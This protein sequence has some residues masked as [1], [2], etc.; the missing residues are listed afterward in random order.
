MVPLTRARQLPR[1]GLALVFLLAA[2]SV[3]G[4][5]RIQGG[6]IEG[7]VTADPLEHESL[8]FCTL[9]VETISGGPVGEVAMIIEQDGTFS[10]DLPPGT[11]DLHANC[12]SLSGITSVSVPGDV[13]EEIEITVR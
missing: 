7:R 9:T 11:Y 2:S 1:V 4:C 12:G 5:S 13:G 6:T 3:D 10:W 8:D